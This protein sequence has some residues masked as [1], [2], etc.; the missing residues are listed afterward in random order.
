MLGSLCSY[1]PFYTLPL[2]LE[3]ILFSVWYRIGFL[4]DITTE[5]GFN[6]G[7]ITIIPIHCW[8]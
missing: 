3:D 2:L 4:L 8:L 6:Y 5:G 7:S 1:V